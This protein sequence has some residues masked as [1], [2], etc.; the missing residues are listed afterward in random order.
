MRT[1]RRVFLKS[2]AALGLGS[3][4]G[5]CYGFYEAS[6]FQVVRRTLTI[7]HLPPSFRG[8]QVAFLSDLHHGPYVDIDYI[9]SIV[10]TTNLLLPDLILHG[11][12]Y[13][14]RD[15]KFIRPCFEVLADLRAPLGSFGVLG[16]HDYWHGL[17]A[18]RDGMKFAK[19][20][21]LT[22]AGVWLTKGND[23]IRLGGVDDFTDG[24][25]NLAPVLSGVNEGDA[26]LVVSHNPDFV[27]TITDRRVG[28]VL[29]GHTHGGQVTVPGLS[30]PW[31]PSRHG[32][33]YAHGLVE[34]PTTRVYVSR[35]L[36]VSGVPVRFGC[37]PE[38]SLITLAAES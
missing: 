28:L 5:T 30:L 10:R 11:G 18:T 9:V 15:A 14:L 12:D 37:P 19:I 20:T 27:E 26:C 7:P 25:P 6:T 31:I 8:L 34:G 22:N 17:Q 1:S 32:M 4:T 36:G 33:K 3:V 38:I 23:R 16:N 21:E 29:S 24:K 2:V 13:S 35:G